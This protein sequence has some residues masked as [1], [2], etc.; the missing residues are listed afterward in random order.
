MNNFN[1][2]QNR[3]GGWR[4]DE[5]GVF[6]GK[7][8]KGWYQVWIDGRQHPRVFSNANGAKEFAEERASQ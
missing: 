7:S 8:P 5:H 6:V 1:W 3:W 2:Q 4:D